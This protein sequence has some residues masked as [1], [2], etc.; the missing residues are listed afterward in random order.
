MKLNIIKK[1]VMKIFKI[2]INKIIFWEKLENQNKKIA[3]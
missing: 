3:R 1:N 2:S